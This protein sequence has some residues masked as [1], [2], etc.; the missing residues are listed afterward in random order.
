METITL[1]SGL[2]L[3]CLLMMVVNSLA[4][5]NLTAL[6]KA[7]WADSRNSQK[8][9]FQEKISLT[10][11]LSQLESNFNIAFL[12]EAATTADKLAAKGLT[13]GKQVDKILR[14]ILSPHH[15]DFQ[16]IGEKT[17]TIFPVRKNPP[18][19]QTQQTGSVEGS[20]KDENGDA[21]VGVSV[22]LESTTKGSVTDLDGAFAIN[23][24]EAG[25]YVL[26]AS[27]VGYKTKKQNISVS[28]GQ[29]TQAS[30]QLSPDLLHLDDIVVT[31]VRNPRAK[32]E[33]SVAIT[34]LSSKQIEQKAPINTADLLKTIPG[35]YVESSGGDVGN[36]LFARGI[37]AAGAY[38]FVQVQ[39]DGLPVFEDGALQFANA[40]NFLRVDESIDKMESVRGGSG[41]IFASNAPG[42]IINF[43]SK[44]GGPEFRGV[45][46]ITVSDYGMFRTDLNF[47]GPIGE[48]LR[49]NIGGFYRYDEGIRSTGYPA[50]LGGQIKANLTYLLDNGHVR[51]YVK[52]LD[53]RNLFYTPIPLK[54]PDDPEGIP[55][56]DPNFGTFSSVNANKLRIPL[57]EGGTFERSLENGVHPNV[58]AFGGEF[59]R[60]L[61]P[62]I[63]FKNSL[64]RTV[65]DL[66]YDALF[67]GAPP[68]NAI[69]FAEAA[70]I[71]NPIYSYADTG[72][73]ILNPNSLNGNGLVAQ[74]G[75]W[76]I[77]KQ[78]NSFANNMQ[79]SFNYDIISITAG[80][81]FANY[82]ADQQWNWSNILLEI[83]EEPRLLNIADGDLDPDDEGYYLT[84]DGVTQ[85]TWL[86][87]RAQTRGKINAFFLN[88]EFDLMDQLT[89]DLGGR[90]EIA[91]YS[92]FGADAEFFSKDLGDPSTRADDAVT[93]LTGPK[94]YWTYD[95]D[96]FAGSLGANYKFNENMATYV[97]V[98][99]GFRSPIEEAYF[100]NM[101]DLSAIKPTRVTQVELGYKYSSPNLAVFANAFFMNMENLA[102]TDIKLSGESENKFA[103][104]DNFGLEVETIVQLGDFGLNVSGTV[105]N[106]EF[107]DFE[108]SDDEGNITNNN[109]KQVRRIPKIFLTVRP[110]YEI[111]QGLSVFGEYQYF[112]E[113]FSD[114]ENTFRLPAYS[115]FNAGAS[116]E[117]N[118]LRFAANITNIGNSIGLTEGNPRADS[119]PGEFFMARPILGRAFRASISYNF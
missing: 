103:G 115:V 110:S 68:T 24:V 70:G 45:G 64:R 43:I 101:N 18:S 96:E 119:A 11:A 2:T 1:R 78:M 114:N 67:S 99:S 116:Y 95:V 80:Y 38:E 22:Y 86:A 33:S 85:I 4:E 48:K 118:N 53:D 8:T 82:N 26:V 102:F 71:T 54:N 100:D 6:H 57:A 73:E 66:Q 50:N 69:E 63:T 29:A 112:G 28:N 77:E 89:I 105:Q 31:G 30:F 65:I 61:S 14:N 9:V 44:T 60:D 51:V 37:P 40:D 5:Q 49:Y 16:K 107:K 91:R 94:R 109:G 3:V 35:F 59:I 97:R 104:A 75:F 111:I 98:S 106:P 108:F 17:Y 20:V 113:K 15:L 55:G 36:N 90:Y 92:G 13:E 72:E 23:G 74:V 81:Y 25:S 10:K 42:G 39:E 34:T 7:Q 41:A 19:P 83:A 52:K 32:I 87:R 47:G 88:T 46:K 12:Y 27:F 21:L 58:T 76:T 117:I 56:F 93:V 79:F 84:Q 62:H